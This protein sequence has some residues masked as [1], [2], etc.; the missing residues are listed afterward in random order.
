LVIYGRLIVSLKMKKVRSSQGEKEN[1][2]INS[3][4]KL[5]RTNTNESLVLSSCNGL[6]NS[7]IDKNPKT[8]DIK[9]KIILLYS[10]DEFLKH[11]AFPKI[12]TKSRDL[13]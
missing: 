8:I 9:G 3:P 12:D 4:K 1:Q 5:K 11:I 6:L 10:I 7:K 13:N 2:N